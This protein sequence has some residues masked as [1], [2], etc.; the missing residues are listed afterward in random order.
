M[1]EK[2]EAA[3]W[4]VINAT[5]FMSETKS[6]LGTMGAIGILAAAYLLGIEKEC[7]KALSTLA[8]ELPSRE[9]RRIEN[10]RLREKREKTIATILACVFYFDELGNEEMKAMLSLLGCL[11]G[12]GSVGELTAVVTPMVVDAAREPDAWRLLERV[13]PG[14]C[15][16]IELDDAKSAC[17]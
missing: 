12:A 8:F 17:S 9:V 3:F 2:R 5:E 6:E 1:D 10:R 13:F 16:L 4:W 7:A 15:R 14:L 11:A